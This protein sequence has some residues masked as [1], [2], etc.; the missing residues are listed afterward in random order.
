LTSLTPIG[1]GRILA[2]VVRLVLLVLLPASVCAAQP[3]RTNPFDNSAADIDTGRATFR[4]YCA[5]CHGIGA[6]G[7]TGPDLTLG[8]YEVGDSDEDLFEVIKDGVSGTEMSGFGERMNDNTI[9]RVLAYLRSVARRETPVL[10]GDASRGK[11]V[12]QGK[13]GCAGC[14]RIAGTGG[15][16]GPNLSRIGRTLSF[17][18][19]REALVEPSKNIA[20]GFDTITVVERDGETVRG[21]RM[22]ID[23]FSV[24]LMD[25][26]EEIHSYLRDE[27]RSIEREPKSLMPSYAR[28]LSGSEIDDVLAYLVSLR[29]DE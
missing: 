23:N 26:R 28:M 4:I 11:S 21:R 7:G 8:V 3:T 17:A 10:T 9:W 24:Q 20:K 13:G 16:L 25:L 15:R 29:G 18:R 12:Y 6:A 5:P 22:N 27:V 14:H 2:A 1:R 19:L